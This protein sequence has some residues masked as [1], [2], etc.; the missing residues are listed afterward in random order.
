MP[1]DVASMRFRDPNK[2]RAGRYKYAA[3]AE[4]RHH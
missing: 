4:A 1:N 2:P 3:M